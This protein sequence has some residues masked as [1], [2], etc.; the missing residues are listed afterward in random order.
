MENSTV[1]IEED[2]G[3]LHSMKHIIQN[4]QP[5][6][7]KH[8]I[9]SSIRQVLAYHGVFL[10]EAMLFGLASAYHFSYF[11]YK[12]ILSPFISGRVQP[13]AFEENLARHARLDIKFHKT[14]SNQKAWRKV[15]EKI[16]LDIP[17]VVYVDKGALTYLRMP[18]GQHFGGHAVVV[19]GYDEQEGI[20][21]L[22]DR[23][24]DGFSIT[25]SA[26]EIPHDF[27]LVPFIE[28][29]EARASRFKPLPPENAWL[30]IGMD[31]PVEAPRRSQIFA[32][33]RENMYNY[34]N[35][36]LDKMGL[37]GI[38][39]FS[40]V[41]DT[42]QEWGADKL[43]EAALSTFTM[44]DQIGGTGGGIFRKLYGEFLLESAVY[45]AAPA[46]GAIGEQYLILGE[47]W[48][49]VARMFYMLYQGEQP[50]ILVD[51]VERIKKIYKY[52]EGLSNQLVK[53][54]GA[55]YD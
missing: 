24:R 7:G 51:I 14:Q 42:W 50:M 8:S 19:F 23:D 27:H 38:S 13:R 10:S 37:E 4:F 43:G 44:I 6:A 12:S 15:K 25:V 32:A 39:Y 40:K 20:V 26:D 21:F 29:E 47:Q 33:I 55:V 22:S 41:L 53:V 2:E 11:E 16:D 31:V 17:V 46:L 30:T 35:P 45:A 3:T 48:D 9:T 52:E 5:M 1:I 36:P 54:I 18:P 49:E 28:L 34:L